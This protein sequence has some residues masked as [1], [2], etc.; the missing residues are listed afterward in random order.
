MNGI[1]LIIGGNMG[2]RENNLLECKELIINAIGE[3]KKESSI[4]ETAAWGKTDQPSFLNQVF[5]L[6]SILNPNQILG[7]CL[8][9][10]SQMGRIRHEKWEARK[11]DIDI[12]LFNNEVI[13]EED[14]SIPHP[15]MKNRRFVLKPLADIAPNVVHPVYNKTIKELLQSCPDSLE[16]TMFK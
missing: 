9:I 6:E 11:I 16:V 4:Y 13:D 8:A 12:L 1:Y 15:H 2:D 14:L 7:T 5:F 3:I 10:E